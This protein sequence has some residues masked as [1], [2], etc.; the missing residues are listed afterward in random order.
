MRAVMALLCGAKNQ[1]GRC[2]V[3]N[4]FTYNSLIRVCDMAKQPEQALKMLAP[5]GH[6]APR[7]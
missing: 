1:Q 4:L 3:P 5:E 6:H 2:V 7:L